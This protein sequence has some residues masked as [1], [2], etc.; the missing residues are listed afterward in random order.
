MKFATLED[1]LEG[2]IKDNGY[3]NTEIESAEERLK[4][5]FPKELIY[6][7][8]K[9]GRNGI[10]NGFNYL[11][12][13]N[14]L[15]IHDENLIFYNENQACYRWFFKVKELL[16]GETNIYGMDD[17][18]ATKLIMGNMEDFFTIECI[19]NFSNAFFSY[20]LSNN[21][22]RDYMDFSLKEIISSSKT[23]ISYSWNKGIKWICK[24]VSCMAFA[25]KNEAFP[26]LYIFTNS[27]EV[28]L[29]LIKKNRGVWE[30]KF[31][32]KVDKLG[33][34]RVLRYEEEVDDNPNII[35]KP[36]DD[37]LPF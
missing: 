29:K 16:K 7:Y 25:S 10:I 30:V 33:I 21:F 22:Y 14:H 24:D 8:S 26:K 23:D 37:G 11:I 4:I 13:P 34:P 28:L 17:D 35:L 12:P 9:F 1:L 32:K 18:G 5:K 2:T 36:E 27:E 6:I 3:T 19:F 20:Q 31:S 15:I